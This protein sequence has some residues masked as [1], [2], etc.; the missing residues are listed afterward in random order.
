[1]DK[2]MAE[3]FEQNLPVRVIVGEG[4]QRDIS[5]PKSRSASR[6]MLRVLYRAN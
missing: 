2:V 4:S 6:M 1:M 5:D 3:A